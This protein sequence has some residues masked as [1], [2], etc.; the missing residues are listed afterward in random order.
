[1]RRV[2]GVNRDVRERHYYS[3]GKY[4]MMIYNQKKESKKD[5]KKEMGV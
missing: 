3:C 4:M 2:S 5:G 1:M